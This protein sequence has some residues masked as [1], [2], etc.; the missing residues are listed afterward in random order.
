MS[1]FN[2]GIGH[3]VYAEAYKRL[4]SYRAVAM[5]LG[6][7]HSTVR[8]SIQRGNSKDP[9][10]GLER[11]GY[12]ISGEDRTDKQVWDDH[13][14][15]FERK[16]GKSIAKSDQK[17]KRN[18]PWVLFHA[19]DEHVDDDA[20]ALKV[21]EDDINASRELNAIMAHGGDLLN[22][23]PVAGKLAKQWAEQ[24]CTMPDALRRAKYFIEIFQPDLWVDGN[25]EE[26]NPYLSHL[27]DEWLPKKTLRDHWRLNF[28]VDVKD[29]R[30][31][32]GSLSH[33]FQKG[34]S[35]FHGMH[36]HLRE[37][38]ESEARDLYMDG[39]YH[40]SGMMLHTLPERQ[41]TALLIASS[42]YKLVDKWATRISRGGKLPTL[43]GRAHWIVGDPYAEHDQSL[44]HGFRSA[45]E[46]EAFLSGLQNLRAV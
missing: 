7:H 4:G 20:S 45:L 23:W 41:H 13:V 27:L 29:G 2:K 44:C 46:A 18:G 40:V 3:E 42:G 33:K 37:M 21:L 12:S 31:V 10:E 8:Q 26:M 28:V 14:H 11:A 43:P 5:E 17:I 15:A 35:W 30:S 22:N 36:G 34:S 1:G 9:V 32:Y 19:T 39:H 38:L 16:V 24:S 25:H 6:V